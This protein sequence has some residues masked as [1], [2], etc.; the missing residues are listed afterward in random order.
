MRHDG[1]ARQILFDKDFGAPKAANTVPL[2]EHQD[3]LAEAETRGYRNGFTAA[4]QE[5]APPMRAGWRVAMERIATALD[6]LAR[7]L[8]RRRGPGRSGSGRGRGR[9]C[10]ASSRRS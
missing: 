8:S 6:D 1:S 7:G 3:R 4:E 9:R 2:A 10:E 5:A